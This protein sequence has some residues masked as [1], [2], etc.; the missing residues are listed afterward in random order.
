MYSILH[1]S[2]LHRAK[3]DPLS[4]SEILSALVSDRECY[5]HENP[6]IKPPDAIVVSGDVIQGVALNHAN[7]EQEIAAQYD[8][9]HDFLVSLVDCFLN[10]DRTKIIIVPGNHDIDWN[11]AYSSMES[12]TDDTIPLN[13]PLALFERGSPYRWDWKSRNL[14]KIKDAHRYDRRL[15][16]FWNFFERFYSGNNGLLKVAPWSNANLYSLDNG[17]IGVAAFNS[18]VGNDCFAFHGEISREAVAQ[19]H[20]DLKE[21]GPWKLR[22]AVWHH[23]IEGPPLRSDY[24]DLEIVRGMIG[25][26]FRLGLYGHQHRV[27]ITPHHAHLLNQETM[28][29]A[30]AGSLCAGRSELPMGALRGYSIIEIRDDYSGARVHVREM[31]I[32]NLFSRAVLR[33]FE[34]RSYIDLG[35]TTP[36]DAAGRPESPSDAVRVATLRK[37]EDAL[38]GQ[39]DPV[40]ALRLLSTIDVTNDAFGRRLLVEAAAAREDP[41]ML[42][43]VMGEPQTIDELVKLV[44]AHISAGAY[45][46]AESVIAEYAQSLSLPESINVELKTAIKLRKRIK[47]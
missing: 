6:P 3:S 40:E 22:I 34:G 28:V 46:K 7:F 29:V 2:D 30:S 16:A 8:V 32:A 15:A 12:V 13:L 18:C 24:M 41:L 44:S 42:I 9:A 11:I 36:L 10:G 25:R 31:R 21:L 20:L 38:R 19:A 33:D 1:I 26:G 17:N 45:E 37:A 43:E 23:D 47:S 4:N 5:E 27:Q 39:N 35:W 14:Y